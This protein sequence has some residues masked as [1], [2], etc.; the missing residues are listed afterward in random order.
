[1]STLLRFAPELARW[2]VD[3]LDGGQSPAALV[4]TMI[5]EQMEPTIAQAIVDHFLDARRSGRP[6]PVDSITVQ[7][8]RP[9]FVDEPPL[10]APGARLAAGDRTVRVVARCHGP[11]VAVLAELLTA[12]ECDALITLARPRLAP[13][14]VVDPQTGRDVI[15]D[16][17]NSLGMFFRPG[18]NPLVARLDRRFS[19]LMN[20][21]VAHG[22]GIQ[23]LCY[24]AGGVTSPHFDFLVPGNQ[25]NRE[26][27]A[28]SGQR[29][30]TLIAYL[31]DVEEGGETVFPRAGLTV[32]PQ[33]G[34]GLYFESCNR[35]G[36]VDPRSLHAGL[37]VVRGEKWIATKWMRQRP[38][39]P[40]G[41]ESGR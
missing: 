5:A 24:G 25:A 3:G 9:P 31:N 15:A 22:E 23:V 13:S 11:T 30:S 14:R 8:E 36:Q 20:L 21:P 27:L 28:R 39:V 34:Q 17:R 7:D 33:A 10:L 1:V 4:A 2:L 6:V 37:P 40:A 16:H 19:E 41:V 32:S 38:F 29:V 26:S 12:Q 35:R 18:E